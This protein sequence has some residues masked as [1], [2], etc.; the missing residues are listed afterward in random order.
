MAMDHMGEGYQDFTLPSFPTSSMEKY[1]ELI[2]KLADSPSRSTVALPG[3]S[4]GTDPRQQD[5]PLCQPSQEQHAVG[6]ERVLT[7]TGSG[8]ADK[9][10]ELHRFPSRHNVT[11]GRTTYNASHQE[12]SRDDSVSLLLLHLSDAGGEGVDV[13]Q[14]GLHGDGNLRSEAVEFMFVGLVCGVVHITNIPRNNFWED[15]L[16]FNL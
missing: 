5:G 6:G 8:S 14:H 16:P 13:V 9:Q 3:R 4:R 12:Q 1:S 15:S 7:D 10:D 11:D 2:W